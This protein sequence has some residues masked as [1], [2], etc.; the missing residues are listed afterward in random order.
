[1]SGTAS[2]PTP[3]PTLNASW[4]AVLVLP[5]RILLTGLS[6]LLLLWLSKLIIPDAFAGVQLPEFRGDALVILVTVMVFATGVALLSFLCWLV[7]RFFRLL[8]EGTL[9]EASLSSMR[10]LPLG[11]PDGTVRAILALIVAVV[12]LPLLLLSA[13]MNIP[14][15]VAGYINGIIV[16]VFSFYFGSKVAGVPPA[17]VRQMADSEQRAK[18]S[19]TAAKESDTRATV[20]EA[21]ADVLETTAAASD[22]TAADA[23]R[24]GDFGGLQS[25]LRQHAQ[26]ASALL[27][28]ILPLL[29]EGTLPAAAIDTLKKADGVISILTGTDKTAATDDQ[30]KTVKDFEAALLGGSGAGPAP[31][32]SLLQTAAPLLGSVAIPGIGP[33]AAIAAVI[34]VGYKLSSAGFLRWRSRVLA[35]PLS[36]GLV[37]FGT[38]TP[39]EIRSALDRSPLFHDVFSGLLDRSNLAADLLDILQQPD[40]LAD[41]TIK[42]GPNSA[43][44]AFP[45]QETLVAALAQLNQSVLAGRAGSDIPSTLPAQITQTF[46]N[47]DPAIKMPPG[48]ADTADQIDKLIDAASK[49]SAAAS[50]PEMA[51]AAFDALVML[52]GV[53]RQKGIDLPS[54]LAELRS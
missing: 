17:A 48:R 22:Q 29:P 13:T 11:L 53:A 4:W 8:G 51:R 21:R 26:L 49:A 1:M 25:S 41:L 32:L 43:T 18:D 50:A 16:G 38:T 42:Y 9:S 30:I 28:D 45:S 15:N 23:T 24:A 36:S 40:P 5:L 27:K 3:P 37:D 7:G 6:V 52:T 35:V 14:Q 54:V 47:A 10:D 46:A 44:P 31:L 12:G 19:Y 33:V 39:D 20:A 2:P 34:S